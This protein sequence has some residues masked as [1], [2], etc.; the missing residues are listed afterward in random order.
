M[1]SRRSPRLFEGA[2]P[3]NIV[4]SVRRFHYRGLDDPFAASLNDGCLTTSILV[5][6][7]SLQELLGR[8]VCFAESDAYKA[9]EAL[10][11][12]L[13]HLHRGHGLAHGS[14]HP[15]N[16]RMG[17][18]DKLSILASGHASLENDAFVLGDGEAEWVESFLPP[19]R[20]PSSRGDIYSIG[21]LLF[22]MCTQCFPK[23]SSTG[24]ENMA[25][26]LSA[27]LSE[28]LAGLILKCLSMEPSA[29]FPD[30]KSLA[31][32]ANKES[33]VP[34]ILPSKAKACKK[35]GHSLFLAGRARQA[36]EEWQEALKL[37]PE[38]GA[39]H[40]NLGVVEMSRFN[41]L[42]AARHFERA[43]DVSPSG[44]ARANLA[45]CYLENGYQDTALELL[46]TYKQ[47]SPND[48]L[49]SIG[50]AE[51]AVKKG[52]LKE[53]NRQIDGA[54]TMLAGSSAPYHRVLE[55]LI[56]VGRSDEVQELQ[57]KMLHLPME[58]PLVANLVGKD[59]G[60]SWPKTD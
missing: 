18:Q 43:Y 24:R 15:W 4:P 22:R 30:V 37:D 26:L 60:P 48:P 32:E 58:H 17:P 28:S 12:S 53:A 51:I 2:P 14:L 49:G 45:F 34:Y 19:E 3:A 55:L 36:Q 59:D 5:Q 13:N 39:I 29:R 11:L 47:L 21:A 9:V 46:K 52:D 8:G 42:E 31:F 23:H 50:E 16:I 40:N 27:G 57:K 25:P 7:R 6:G 56:K 54:T 44:K 33:E 38:D 41:W 20:T 35:K 10:C 1:W